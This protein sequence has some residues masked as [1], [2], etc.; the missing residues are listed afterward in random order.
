M[1]TSIHGTQLRDNTIDLAAKGTSDPF[2]RGNHTGTQAIS[3]ISLLQAALDDKFD[4]VDA[5]SDN[6]G[7]DSGVTGITV[8]DALDNLALAITSGL[9]FKGLW[10]ANTNTPTLASGV[11]DANSYYIVS[12]AGTTTLDG[13]DD[14]G[15]GDWLVFVNS[16]WNKV[17]NTDAVNSVFGRTGT[18]TAQAGD[19]TA[20]QVT[21]TPSGDQ[22]GTNVQA[23]LDDL[24]LRK[25]A[26]AKLK[27][28][29]HPTGII[30][31]LNTLFQLAS[32]P[33]TG[34]VEVSYNGVIQDP[35]DDY[36]IS[37]ADITFTSAP[38]TGSKVMASS[39]EA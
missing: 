5:T 17:D 24:E 7:N 31:S 14:W 33:I 36:T 20:A 38:R 16:A 35:G 23:L 25:L 6:I 22:T 3:T 11:G 1:A 12:V 34:T 28:N 30:N 15:V 37:G 39:I 13:I 9:E 18:V 10:N 29:E 21:A 27:V 2:A 26:I 8:S 32:T 4:A 19:Y